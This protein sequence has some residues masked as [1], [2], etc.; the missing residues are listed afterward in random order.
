V[1]GG[2][3]DSIVIRPEAVRLLADVDRGGLAFDGCPCGDL[4]H[5]EWRRRDG[6]PFSD[7]E[8]DLLATVTLD[9]IKAAI[10]SMQAVVDQAT[11]AIRDVLAANLEVLWDEGEAS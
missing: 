3:V 4:R 11:E 5:G 6:I 1:L 2:A 10:A 7:A 8:R 9:E